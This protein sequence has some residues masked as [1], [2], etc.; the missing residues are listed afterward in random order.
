MVVS[1]SNHVQIFFNLVCKGFSLFSVHVY[2]FHLSFVVGNLPHV[3][4]KGAHAPQLVTVWGQANKDDKRT[5]SGKG[6]G[7]RTMDDK[8]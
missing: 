8:T 5:F 7:E 2:V 6:G 1:G 4:C 3:K